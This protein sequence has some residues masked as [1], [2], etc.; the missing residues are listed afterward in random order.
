MIGAYGR[1]NRRVAGR[2]GFRFHHRG[3]APHGVSAFNP[4]AQYAPG[5]YV[6]A[7]EQDMQLAQAGLS[8][9]ATLE[10]EIRDMCNGDPACMAVARAQLGGDPAA[11][12]D[13]ANAEP[14][15][16]ACWFGD[17]LGSVFGV[18]SSSRRR[19]GGR[20]RRRGGRGGGRGRG[21]GSRMQQRQ[22]RQEQQQ[23]QQSQDGGGGGGDE[24]GGSFEDDGYDEIEDDGGDGYDGAVGFAP[25]Y[26]THFGS[27]PVG[28]AQGIAGYG[29]LNIVYGGYEVPASPYMSGENYVYGLPASEFGDQPL[30]IPANADGTPASSADQKGAAKFFHDIFAGIGGGDAKA[31]QAV[32]A[33]AAMQYGPDVAAGV[34]EYLKAKKDNP[35]KIRAKIA[36]CKGEYTLAR[37]RGDIV[38]ATKAYYKIKALEARLAN[39][40]A[41]L[42]R[43]EPG[44]SLAY[45]TNFSA[46]G[47]PWGWVGGGLVALFVAAAVFS[48]KK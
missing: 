18:T 30:A 16:L 42:E 22:Q 1:P 11:Q 20:R 36:R 48:K 3:F 19:G 9:P 39:L 40:G 17:V 25:L 32:V 13:G 23:Q 43:V 27:A 35:D 38:K 15:G 31:G 12:P 41:G 37:K 45:S 28:A 5:A 7:Q 44:G 10:D 34:G 21:G 47:I 29:A 4:S 24:G 8:I 33:N 46:T 14:S 6:F 2:A 26:G